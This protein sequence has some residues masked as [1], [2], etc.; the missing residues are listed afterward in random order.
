MAQKSKTT[1]W[2]SYFEEAVPKKVIEDQQKK[3]LHA[4]MYNPIMTFNTLWN[5]EGRSNRF[6]YHLKKLETEGM[7]EKTASGYSLTH[8]GKEYV[9]Y[10]ETE[11]GK[12]WKF[13]V[14]AVIPVIIDEKKGKILMVERRKEPFRGYW[15][16]HGGKLK[17][18]QY[19]LECAQESLKE[20]TG[21]TCNLE[22]KGLFSSKTYN[23]NGLS[24]SHQ[25]FI[26]TGTNPRG[27]LLKKSRKGLNK[28]IKR[29]E[30]EKLKIL[31]N[32]PLLIKIALSK[33][34]RWI[35]ADRFQEND[36]FKRVVI[37]KDAIL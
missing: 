24:Y 27:K 2:D 3:I 28:W 32:I 25:L 31:P 22:L 12:E 5:K 36:V 23:N 37:K 29:G 6:A 10:M 13:P 9:A 21:L 7:V 18:S 16:F 4:L 11:T 19:L 17:F 26:V 14:M 8:Q 15:G 35:E 34:F 1:L 33:R 30:V 20:E